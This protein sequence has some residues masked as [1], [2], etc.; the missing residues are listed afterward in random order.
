MDQGLHVE[1]GDGMSRWLR[2]LRPSVWGPEAVWPASFGAGGFLMWELFKLIGADPTK[3]YPLLMSW[4]PYVFGIVIVAVILG[5][6]FN[7]VMDV[8]ADN[9]KAGRETATAL[10]EISNRLPE[11]TVI[12]DLRL[13]ISFISQKQADSTDDVSDMKRALERIE[14]HLGVQPPSKEKV[15]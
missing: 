11:K 14:D 12:D 5:G 6:C 8:L 7:R 1:T 15:T 9:A 4:G 10:T 3:V 13:Q 2:A